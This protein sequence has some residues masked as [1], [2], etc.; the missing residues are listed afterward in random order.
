MTVF[1]LKLFMT[2]TLMLAISLAGKRWGTQIGG[3][4]SGLPVTSAL[5]MLFL[6]LEQGE[7]FASLAVPGALAGVAAVQATCLFYYGVTR[8]VGALVG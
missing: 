4:L 1:Y 6:S 2:P 7:G 3:L 8:R 5:V